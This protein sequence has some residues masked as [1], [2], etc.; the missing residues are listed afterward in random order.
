MLS[1]DEI[2]QFINDDEASERKKFAK[3]G[4]RYYDGDND[5][6]DYRMFYYNADGN[7][8][9][10][11]FRTNTK[12]PHNFMREL[13]D[14]AAQYIL[15]GKEGYMRSDIP[16][17]QEQLDIY[18]NKNEDFTSELMEL[19]TGCMIKG[20]EYMYAYKNENNKLAFECADGIGVVEVRAKDADDECEHII[21]WYIDRIEKGTKKIKRIQVWDEQQTYFYCQVDDGE[22]VEDDS[23]EINPR[24]HIILEDIKTGEKVGDT[25]GFMP[26]WR[27]DNNRKQ[28][29]DLKSIKALI[30]DY[31]IHACSLSNNLIDFDTPL[32]VV[33]GFEGDNLTE[34][35]QNLKTKKV[36]GVGDSGG[37][38]IQT[39][40][41][42][43]EARRAKLDIDEQAI[44]KFG[45]GLNTAG[46]KDTAAT[47]NIAIKAAYSLLD[48]KANKLVINV[49]KFLRKILKPVLDEI[50]E[51][52]KSDYQLKDVDIEF[53]YEVMSN[54]TENAQIKLIEAQEQ[55][56]RITT[57]L[58]IG[59]VIGDE[60]A[61][62]AICDVMDMDF[63]ELKGQLA[64]MREE[65]N[66]AEAKAELQGV[67]TEG[68]EGLPIG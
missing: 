24:P 44:Y 64:L 50:N 21:Y 47:T 60:E 48:L 68:E 38:D 5:I 67:P 39:V 43:Y 41:I 52:L 22:I 46:L 58:N 9:E 20:F 27:L 61:L 3:V 10:D 45:F 59:G 30:D 56:T 14:Q 62:K 40:Q 7:L 15:S 37:V 8:E 29:S 53:E 55:Q 31:D 51:E 18:F 35:Q 65:Q 1:I 26:F 36:I 54:S 4:Q 2:K 63:E 49:K 57:I 12:I 23:V 11:K 28:F 19:L 42:P 33:R 6:K 16:E 13:V 32:H 17:L 66:T 25:L 34:L